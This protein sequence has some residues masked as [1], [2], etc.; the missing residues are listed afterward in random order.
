MFS[1]ILHL[2]IQSPSFFTKHSVMKKSFSIA[3]FF[4]FVTSIK[5]QVSQEW[6]QTF[7][8][9]HSFYMAMDNDGN[10]YTA[11]PSNGN[12]LLLKYDPAGN[13]LWSQIYPADGTTG[14]AVDGNG[15]VILTGQV[16]VKYDANGSLLWTASTSF[17]PKSIAIDE[18]NNIYLHGQGSAGLQTVKLN[19]SGVQQWIATYTGDFYDQL[20]KKMVYKNGYIYVTGDITLTT[21]PRNP[22]LRHI[23]TMKY[24][25]STGAQV[26]A[27]TYTHADKINQFGNDL[28][29]DGTGNVYVTARVDVKVGSKTHGNWGTLKYNASGTLQWVKFYDGN[30]IEYDNQ[31]N[32]LGSDVP[33]DIAFD[34]S[35]NIIVCGTSYTTTGQFTSQDMTTIKYSPSGTQLWVKTY[36]DPSHSNDVTQAITSDGSSNIYLTGNAS[37]TGYQN[38]TTIKYSSAGDLQWTA[39][40]N[41]GVARALLL[42][43]SEN[44]YV[45]GAAIPNSLLIKYSQGGGPI[46]RKDIV[47]VQENVMN[48]IKLYP[49]PAATQITIQNINNKMLGNLKIYDA[50]GKMIYKK[51][52]PNNQT[53]IDIKRLSAGIYYLQSDKL[54]ATIKFLKH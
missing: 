8:A 42:D 19:S 47:P 40:Y 44:V 6:V 36:D 12:M 4:L 18:S 43:N 24:N 1:A 23:L 21:S 7:G 2:S 17:L 45:C 9:A 51:F 28:I 3:L 37:K 33:Y 39:N 53:I 26:W 31:N 48:Q 11:G 49:N 27:V 5:A 30:A 52:E 22:P 15:E 14:V 46:T 32:P 50:S 38:A 35:G 34:N 10:I 54:Q 41:G 13:L 16:T 29:V 25:A 20:R